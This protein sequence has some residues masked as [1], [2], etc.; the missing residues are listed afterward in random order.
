[1]EPLSPEIHSKEFMSDEK[2]QTKES[3]A[4]EQKP[5]KTPEGILAGVPGKQ[6]F[7]INGR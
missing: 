7:L 6:L 2:K 4:P 5:K 3:K 1:V